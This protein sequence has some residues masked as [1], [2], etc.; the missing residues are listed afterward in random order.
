MTDTTFIPVILSGGSGT[1]LWPL[2]RKA[3]PK[4]LLPLIGPES[5]LQ[6]TA[7]RLAGFGGAA[8]PIVIANDDHR[9]LVREQFEQ[10]GMD[11]AQIVLEPMGR[12]TAPAVAVACLIALSRSPDPVL[13]IFASDHKI[14]DRVGFLTSLSKAVDGATAGHIVTFSIRPTRP[15]TGYGYIRHGDPI[16]GTGGLDKVD[17]F[18]EKPDAATASNYVLS[19]DYGWN[20]G[21][22]VFRASVMLAELEKFCPEA[23]AAARAALDKAEED[24]GFTRLAADAFGA[25]PN[26]AIDVAVMERTDKAATLLTDFGWSDLGAWG[27]IHDVT[28]TNGDGNGMVGPVVQR[29]TTNSYL[30]AEDGRLLAA[31]GLDNMVVVSTADAVLVAPKDRAGEVKDLVA[32]LSKSGRAE[33]ETH[34]RVARPWGTYEDVDREDGFRVKRI[35]VKPGGRLSMQRHRQRSEHWVVVRGEAHVTIDDTLQV[36][37]RNQ[38]TYVPIGSTHRLE[39]RGDEPLHLIEV[40]VGDYVEEDD[41]ERLDDVYGRN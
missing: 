36:L 19:G 20:S 38:S 6:A 27:A 30:H 14:D 35:V 23:I 33:A 12:N 11:A 34:R 4:Q 31:I 8:A 25:A 10:I 24:L 17:A 21:M 1:R 2:S 9:F 32:D 16:P 18:V 3:Y 40:Q 15:D 7:K 37:T 41:I 28:E 5:L 26:I 29:G 22:F 13:G 39:N